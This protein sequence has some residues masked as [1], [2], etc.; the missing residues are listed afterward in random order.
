MR[1]G[2][3]SR[4]FPLGLP[5]VGQLRWWHPE[6]D[7]LAAED[8]LNEVR[9]EERK[10]KQPP[11][12]RPIDPLRLRQFLDRSILSALQHAP[13]PER[14]CQR[15]HQRRI[16]AVVV[17]PAPS[18]PARTGAPSGPMICFARRG[19]GSSSAP[20]SRWSCRD[21]LPRL[22]PRHVPRQPG[23]PL[24]VQ[25]DLR[26]GVRDSD[27]LDQQPHDPFLLAR[28]QL[29]PE[30]SSR[31]SASRAS[32]SVR[33]GALPPSGRCLRLA[34]AASHVPTMTSGCRSSARTCAIT[35]PSISPAGSRRT[36]L[37]FAAAFPRRT[38]W[39]TE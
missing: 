27:P 7:E 14:P 9:R 13:P 19:A 15:L 28:E 21:R 12:I 34:R 17:T 4:R 5:I 32:A 18:P 23:E 29:V 8:C 36:P 10:L 22:P 11:D 37:S 2:G 33:S 26:P 39:L 38:A 30:R 35:T 1:G 20:P 25:P 3:K 31:P 16:P 6:I 24:Q